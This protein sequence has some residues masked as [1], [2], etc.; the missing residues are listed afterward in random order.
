MNR[1]VKFFRRLFG[2]EKK[3]DKKMKEL[4]KDIEQIMVTFYLR[5]GYDYHTRQP[6]VKMGN[7]YPDLS[8]FIPSTMNCAWQ[9]KLVKQYP[10]L[11]S[12]FENY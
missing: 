7:L 10:C 4:K 3:S 6:A 2:C 8:E 5:R 9:G 12:S 1:L 11:K